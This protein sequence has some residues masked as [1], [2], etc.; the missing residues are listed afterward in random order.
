MDQFADLGVT[1]FDS[2]SPF[3][4]AFMDDRNNYHTA[5][6]AYVAIRVPQVD[7]NPTLK[8]AILAGDVAQKEALAAERECLQVALRAYDGRA[9]RRSD[10]ACL[11]ALGAYE[12][13]MPVPR[14][15]T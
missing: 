13:V 15:P 10:E 11:D 12:T 6:G 4:Q 8:R 3:R 9:L 7:G 1:S 5:D 2:T 14:R